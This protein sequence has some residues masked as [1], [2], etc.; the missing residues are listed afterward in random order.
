MDSQMLTYLN[1][2]VN[3]SNPYQIDGSPDKL[4]LY[5]QFNPLINEYV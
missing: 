2:G 1:L 5:P 3:N 4:G